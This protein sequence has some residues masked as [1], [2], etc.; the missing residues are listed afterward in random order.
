[1]WSYFVFGLF[2]VSIKLSTL[3]KRLMSVSDKEIS[4]VGVS[5]GA[6][7]GCVGDDDDDEDDEGGGVQANEDHRKKQR[8]FGC[9][10]FGRNLGKA[11]RVILSPF[12]KAKARKQLPRRKHSWASSSCSSSIA[13]TKVTGF[14]SSGKEIGGGGNSKGCYFCFTRPLTM[15]SPAESRT[16]DPN[17]PNFTYDMLKVLIEKSDF[18]SPDCNP[19]LDIDLSL[20]G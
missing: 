2:I 5:G 13:A 17:D 9:G 3:Y 18:Y 14:S 16:S 19:H 11:R 10:G 6:N 20:R 7:G 12:T 4:R 8:G 15:E 1:M